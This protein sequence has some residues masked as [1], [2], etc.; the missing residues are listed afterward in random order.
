MEARRKN[1]IAILILSSWVC[2][3][4]AAAEKVQ[5]RGS[6]SIEVPKPKHSLEELRSMKA[7]DSPSGQAEYQG[8][9]SASAPVYTTTPEANKK[10]KELLDKKKNWI[11][12]NPYESHYDSKTEEFL[13]AEKGTGLY[14]HP[15]LEDDDQTLMEKYLNEGNPERETGNEVQDPGSKEFSEAR[16]EMR[17]ERNEL[18]EER[19]VSPL[20]AE[21]NVQSPF[22]LQPNTPSLFNQKGIFDRDTETRF[23]ETGISGGLD[24]SVSQVELRK[25]RDDRDAEIVRMLQPRSTAA[26][27]PG[28]FSPIGRTLDATRQD[29]APNV[30]GSVGTFGAGA[31]RNPGAINFGRSEPGSVGT[32]IRN[33]P[34]FTGSSPISSPARSGFDFGSRPGISSA[35]AT[36]APTAPSSSITAPA[37]AAAQRP[38]VLPFPKRQF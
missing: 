37:P 6:T 33:G 30:I 18:A 11:F 8:G 19:R 35:P 24:R 28:S 12:M 5:I 9:M 25:E 31:Q 22:S 3:S 26:G 29:S 32:G 10:L 7:P 1:Q 23:Q 20:V 27:A 34:I 13:K 4:G 14:D 38:F 21:R 2:A 17:T 16:Q 36:F 15:L